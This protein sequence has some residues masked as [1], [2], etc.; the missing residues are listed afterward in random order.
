MLSPHSSIQLHF[1]RNSSTLPPPFPPHCHCHLM[2]SSSQVCFITSSTIAYSSF[3]N[4]LTPPP[5]SPSHLTNTPVGC[6]LHQHLHPLNLFVS[7]LPP[8]PSL[9]LHRQHL[10]CKLS[11]CH[12]RLHGF[13]HLLLHS[14]L[15]ST[16][17]AF[18]SSP[19][20]SPPTL[21]LLLLM[22]YTTPSDFKHI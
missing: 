11:S 1:S 16:H 3:I 18:S 2:A 8:P 6:H 5:P 19:M 21:R 4:N 22:G 12:S 10:N 17:T 20:P 13:C 15:P 14:C 9:F 7:L